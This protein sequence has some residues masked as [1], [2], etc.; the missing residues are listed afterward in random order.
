MENIKYSGKSRYLGI[1]TKK[2][3]VNS[4]FFVGVDGTEPVQQTLYYQCF[5]QYF[6]SLSTICPRE[7]R[8]QK[9]EFKIVLTMG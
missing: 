6:L 4:L 8:V 9:E 1:S 7:N 3:S 2:E 5:K